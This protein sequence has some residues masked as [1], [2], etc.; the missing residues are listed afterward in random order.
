MDSFQQD[1][2]NYTVKSAVST[3]NIMILRKLAGVVAGLMSIW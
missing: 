2:A 3:G 1:A